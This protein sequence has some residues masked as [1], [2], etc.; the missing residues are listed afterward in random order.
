MYELVFLPSAQ[1]DMVDIIQYI[2]YTLGDP[3]A[4]ARLAEEMVAEAEKLR[5]FPYAIAV[6]PLIRPLTHEYRAL[7][8]QNY[9]LFYWVEEKAKAITVARVL[10]GHRDHQKLLY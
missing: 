1:R 4:A 2:R 9:L 7:P 10:Y 6:Y 3:Q 5:S 8:V